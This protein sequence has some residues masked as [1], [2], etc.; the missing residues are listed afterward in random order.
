MRP[1]ELLRSSTFRLAIVY[2]VLFAG[3]VLLLLGFIYWSTVA[4]LSEQVDTT[5]ETEIVGLS[6]QYRE[7]GLNGLVDTINDRIERNPDSSSLYL[8]ASPAF[9]PLAGNL[10][11]WPEGAPTREGWLSFPLED[12]AGSGD[13]LLARARVFTLQGSFKLLVGRDVRGL[14]RLDSLR[15]DFRKCGD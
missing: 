10:S 7:R 9:R 13:R 11:G 4:F 8:F 12:P 5:I 2:M 3:S 6:E 1:I 14:G 15:E